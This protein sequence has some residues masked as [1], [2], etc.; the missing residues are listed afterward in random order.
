[1]FWTL[2]AQTFPERTLFLLSSSKTYSITTP[3]CHPYVVVSLSRITQLTVLFAIALFKVSLPLE[4]KAVPVVFLF[5][6]RC[7]KKSGNVNE[8]IHKSYSAKFFYFFRIKAVNY[9]LY[10]VHAIINIIIRHLIFYN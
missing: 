5:G 9:F 2:R 4:T 3:A 8:L 1:V 6:V 7:N 10:I